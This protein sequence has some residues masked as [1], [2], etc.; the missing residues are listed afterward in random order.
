M[1]NRECVTTNIQHGFTLIELAIVLVIIGVLIGSFIGTL[2]TRIEN[3]R[4]S[5]TNKE[6]DEI[7]SALTGYAYT[8]GYLPCPDCI[9]VLCDPINFRDGEEDRDAGGQC[10]VG[11]ST[12]TVPWVTLGMARGDAWDTRYRYWV[13]TQYASSSVPIILATGDGSGTI[14]EPDYVADP[15][16]ATLMDTATRAVAVI[17]SHGKNR[18]GG[19]SASDINQPG[20]PVANVDE[21]NNVDNDTVFVSRPPTTAQATTAG[22]EFDDIVDWISEFELKAKLVEA[23][24]LP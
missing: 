14:R 16:G 20:I 24:R 17:F 9:G 19:I 8:Y 10:D 15:T 13:D 11:L 22:G 12:G 18:L 7:K 2:T 1:L 21:L 3:M 5:E 23:G 6:L 4:V